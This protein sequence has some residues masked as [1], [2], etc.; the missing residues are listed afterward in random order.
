MFY[1][2]PGSISQKRKI[3]ASAIFLYY[4]SAVFGIYIYFFLN[5]I[6]FVPFRINILVSPLGYNTRFW[7]MFYRLPGSISQKRKIAA[8]AIFLY[9][10]SAVNHNFLTNKNQIGTSCALA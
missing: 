9:Y 4:A 2:L 1:R 5:G 10:T 8:S 6:K 7:L 3:A